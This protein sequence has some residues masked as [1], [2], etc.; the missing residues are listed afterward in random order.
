[1]DDIKNMWVM[2]WDIAFDQKDALL[3]AIEEHTENWAD[4]VS[5]FEVADSPPSGLLDSDS[6]P[7]ASIH[8]IEAYGRSDPGELMKF[9]QHKPTRVNTVKEDP[10]WLEPLPPKQV[11]RFWIDAKG[12]KKEGLWTLAIHTATAFGSGEHPTTLGCLTLMDQ[13]QHEQPHL[14]N[15]LDLGCGSGI[16]AIGAY[17][18]WPGANV[19][20]TD[21]DPEAIHVS[22]RHA[23]AHNAPIHTYVSN[24]CE[25]LREK[26][27]DL[28]VA[29]ILLNPLVSMAY[30]IANIG[31]THLITAGVLETQLNQLEQAYAPYWNIAQ[32]WSLNGWAVTRWKR[33]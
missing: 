10:T 31:C 32:S 25:A 13:L 15:I 29:N 9:F 2:S 18:L 26:S 22:E 30:D 24:G 5:V 1:M 16:L 28:V 8:T 4:A 14:T 27:F 11:G 20:A 7:I 3:S 33:K 19:H 6:L 23:K 21:L 17:Y 12:D